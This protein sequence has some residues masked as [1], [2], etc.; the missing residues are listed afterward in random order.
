V[1]QD[2]ARLEA[3]AASQI[4]DTPPENDFDDLARLAAQVCQT[5]AAFVTFV[6]DRRQFFK[7]RI[8]TNGTAAAAAAREAPLPKGICPI[9]VASGDVLVIPD[10]RADPRYADNPAV[11]GEPFVRFYASVPL[12]S[13]ENHTLGT[14]CV[15]D[16]APR[17]ALADE[18][19]MTLRTLARQA[20]A[21]LALRRAL[22]QQQRLLNEYQAS[23]QALQ[24]YADIFHHTGQG[25]AVS[26]Q[27]SVKSMP[28]LELL[29]PAFAR[30]HGYDTVEELAGRPASDVFAPE[31]WDDI[32]ANV[33]RINA[34]GHH[35]YES[36]HVRKDGTR[37][38]V[39][40]DSTAV[41]DEQGRV[42][43]RIN[44]VSDI[45][46]HKEAQDAVARQARQALLRADVN[47]ALAE[48]DTPENVLQRCAD[49]LVRH[50]EGAAFAR[51][52]TLA[53]GED[54]LVLRASA[55]LYTHK[56][57]AHSR[58]P[59]GA[60]K[61]GRIAREKKPHLTNDVQNDPHVS[62][63]EWARREGIVAFAGYAMRVG[64]RVAGVMAL[65]ARKPL[66]P[67]TL[68]DLVSVANVIA[69]GIE[70]R[71]MEE[72]LALHETRQWNFVRTV[73]GSVT[74]GKLRLCENAGDLPARLPTLGAPITLSSRALREVRARTREATGALGFDEE[75]SEDLITGAS[76]ASMNAVV[77]AGGG[78]TVVGTDPAAGTVQVWVEDGGG[79]IA[80]DHLP[81]ATLEPGY[82]VG[83]TPGF[84]HG[85]WLMLQAVDRIW[86]LT[87]PTG[88]TVVLEQDRTPPDPSW[89]Q[90]TI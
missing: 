80:L 86:L 26:I 50:V 62:D 49:A 16:P 2:A 43:Y 28:V 63:K 27:S 73:L 37:F 42:L 54:V 35:A 79:G 83:A 69:Q 12:K 14:L 90:A 76:E 29:N 51:V 20:E 82:S 53:P 24:R 32:S 11:T 47:A 66:A 38:P 6:D 87:G 25:V 22:A 46:E 19:L 70:R 41:K 5:R 58:I 10:A 89:L 17:P 7:A 59:V 18:C 23:A 31:V 84:G 61:I 4:M 33:R 21:L 44:N 57:G 85:F 68:D 39:W 71:R 60:L 45:S 65:F 30:T 74:G 3:L 34:T 72:A 52:W 55:G 1:L 8:G 88:T 40:I 36:V 15:T 56:D 9:V 48:E 13:P 64:R 77:H 75:R 78:T 67:D 81:R